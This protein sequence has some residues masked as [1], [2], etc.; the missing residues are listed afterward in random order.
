[1]QP[2]IRG[3]ENEPQI[4]QMNADLKTRSNAL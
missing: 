4:A 3:D 1:M 2:Q